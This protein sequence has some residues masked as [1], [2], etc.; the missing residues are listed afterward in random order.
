M[1]FRE[2]SAQASCQ[3]IMLVFSRDASW[4]LVQIQM[5]VTICLVGNLVITWLHQRA[6]IFSRICGAW[7]LRFWWVLDHWSFHW[8]FLSQFL[9]FLSHSLMCQA[10]QCPR[11]PRWLCLRCH[12]RFRVS[13]PRRRLRTAHR[14]W[15]STGSSTGSTPNISTWRFM[16][17]HPLLTYL[18]HFMIVR[19][20]GTP[21]LD[22]EA[23]SFGGP[24]WQCKRPFRMFWAQVLEPWVLL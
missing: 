14:H 19:V 9:S 12:C 11:C 7:Q 13:G 16:T 4:C 1:Y 15:G 6:P 20:A 22:A 2:S 10:W 3:S 17:Y 8:S 21:T 18:W 23:P 5:N 24:A